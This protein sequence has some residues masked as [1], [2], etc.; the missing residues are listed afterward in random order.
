[1]NT[2]F[3]I[4]EKLFYYGKICT[5]NAIIIRETC[6][7]YEVLYTTKN[8]DFCHIIEENKLKKYKPIL[9]NTEKRY[10][11]NVIK[12]FK[13][14]VISVI[15]ENAF[16]DDYIKIELKNGDLAT[17]PNFAKGTMY[18]GMK[19]EKKYRLKEL[20]LFEEDR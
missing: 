13:D 19:K 17:L 3:K 12:P 7:E 10:L 16:G 20:G 6:I 2:K 18:K 1:M 15:K 9:D 5:I 4:G 11:E 8:V 14:R